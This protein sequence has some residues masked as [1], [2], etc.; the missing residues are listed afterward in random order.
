MH[1][2]VESRASI[3][4]LACNLTFIS[5]AAYLHPTHLCVGRNH[6][7]ARRLPWV[8]SGQQKDTE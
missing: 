2:H 1:K 4:C 6:P 3:R 5:S 8:K 7:S